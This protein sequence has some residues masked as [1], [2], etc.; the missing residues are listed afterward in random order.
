MKEE[1]GQQELPWWA[2]ELKIDAE[3]VSSIPGWGSKLCHHAEKFNFF[4]KHIGDG[5]GKQKYYIET[6]VWVWC[7][8]KQMGNNMY[9]YT[10]N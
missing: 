2:Q 1:R 10:F 7:K 9:I 3:D 8:I 5:G 6:V 4:S